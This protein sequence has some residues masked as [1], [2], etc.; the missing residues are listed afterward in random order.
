M[1]LNLPHPILTIAAAIISIFVSA[2]P[3]DANP[4]IYE[5]NPDIAKGKHLVLI[6]DDHEYRSEETIPAL[7]RILAK[8][9]GFKCTVLFGID[10]ETGTIVPGHSDIPGMEAL[11]SADGVVIFG[12]FL[13]LPD[14][15]MKHFDDYLQRGGPIVGLRTSTHAFRYPADSDSKYARHDWV[16]KGD[17]YKLGFGYQILGQSWVGHYG[18]NHQQSTRIEIIPEKADNPILKGV[19]DIWVQAGGYNAEPQDDWNILTMAQPL[20]SMEQNGEPDP[21]KP[22]MASEWTRTYKSGADGKEGRAFTSLYGASEDLLNDGYRRMII[23]GVY[24]S[25]GLEDQI[26]ADSPIDFV[27]PYKPN[28]FGYGFAA[29]IK[30]SAY[31]GFTS[32]IPAHNTITEK[33]KE[34]AK[35]KANKEKAK[36]A[37]MP[38][39]SAPADVTVDGPASIVRVSIPGEGRILTL[40]EVEVLNSGGRNVAVDGKATQS[41]VSAG[42]EPQRAI[43]GNKD[44]DWNKKGQTHTSQGKDAKDPW[45]QLDLGK[46]TKIKSIQIWNRSPLSERLD[47]F[48]LEVLN[49]AGEP[50]FVRSNIPAPDGSITFDLANGGAMSMTD[51]Q[52]RPVEM[53]KPLEPVPADY[54][55]PEHTIMVNDSPKK[56]MKFEKG[57]R[58][59][60]IGNTLAERLQH[61]GWM[62]TLLQSQSPELELVFR[63]L[64]LSGDQVDKRPRSKDFTT[65]EE[66]LKICEADVI[67][68][69]FGY[70]ES[71]EDNPDEYAAKLATMIDGY[72]ALR[73]NGESIPRIVLFSPIAHENIKK[74]N[75]NLPNGKANNKRLAAYTESTRKVAEEK[76]VFFVDLFSATQQIYEATPDD[77]MTINGI[78]LNPTG[79]RLLAEVITFALLGKNVED[80]ESLEPVRQAVLDKNWH[81]FMRYRAIDGN[82]IWGSRAD[83]KFTNDQTNREVLVHELLQ[84]DVM[85]ANRD[86]RIW[87]RSRGSDIE[88]DDSNVPAPVKVISNVGGGSKSSSA[89]KEGSLNYISGEEGLKHLTVAEGFEANLFADEEQFPNL[90]NPVQMNVDPKGRLWVAAWPT[91]PKWQPT[92]EMNDALLILHDDDKDGKADRVTEFAKIHS[93]LAFEFWNGGVLV[94]SQPDIVFLKDTDGDD[95]ADHREINVHGIGSSDTHHAANKFIYGPDGALYWQSGVFLQTNIEHP[96]GASMSSGSSA[97]F[98]FDPRQYTIRQHAPNSPNPHGIAFDYWGYHFA[99][100]GTGG[101]AYQVRPEGDGF[102]MHK[103]LE[104]EVRPVPANEIISSA[105]FPDEMQQ[106]FLVCNAIGFLGIKQYQIDRDGGAEYSVTSGKGKEAKTEKFTTKFG[107]LWGTPTEEMLSSSDKNFRPTDAVF[108]ED[109]G[110]YVADWHNVIIGHMQHNVRDPNRD[111]QHGRVYRVIHKQRPLQE[112]VEIAG[113]PLDQLMANLEHPID[114]VRH[115]TRV[116]LSARPTGDVIAACEKWMANWDPKN[117]DHAHHLLEALWLHQ[118]H[119]VR[120]GKLLNQV[121]NSPERHARI[122]AHTVQHHWFNV[123]YKS[124]VTAEEEDVLHTKVE[125][126]GVLS[127]TDDLI[128]VRV[129]TI[130][131]RMKF[132]VE[133]FTVKAGKK[134]ELTFDNPDFLPHNIVITQPGAGQEI[135]LAAMAMGEAGFKNGFIPESDKIIIHSNMLD[136]GTDQVLEFTAPEKPGDYEFVCT[137]PGHYMLMKGVMKVVE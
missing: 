39:A 127:E 20:M 21:E 108:G 53:A 32:P 110:L 3:A 5:A 54:R 134:I 86:P 136:H 71:F 135:A 10:A 15:Q 109:G 48:T 49:S 4:V 112:K 122:A 13:A 113:A 74:T 107:E 131:E 6:G 36:P 92:K 31:E 80:T 87:V 59:A 14:E 95:I 55:D 129:G 18:K 60:I 22:P 62:E 120:N 75:P 65:P 82:D 133:T 66:Y 121:L 69:F 24:W 81:W 30:P 111:H 19:S 124:G 26:V 41:S 91:Y 100:D 85:T 130:I 28:T 9:H 126:S 51:H 63:N 104:K 61:E 23:N 64:G 57:D 47:G 99:S 98:R 34:K 79:N 119:N 93:P 128:T 94:S 116:E 102:A 50:V 118:Q 137:F 56:V 89:E 43:D 44:A 16:Y 115:R 40:A 12:R 76:G 37:K 58:I 8:H 11:D 33:P 2:L 123:D 117:K 27:G 114:G 73:P 88:I 103:L 67:F 125:K 42:G 45:W 68:S 46:D 52:G 38:A 29:G 84:L 78:H 70:N 105:N 7:A 35:P 77:P 17:D 132:D 101:R 83:L 25:L 1:K 96:W 97:M 106:N 90:V 72:R